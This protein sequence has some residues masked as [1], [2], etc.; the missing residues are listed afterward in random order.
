MFWD[1]PLIRQKKCD[2]LQIKRFITERSKS[3]ERNLKQQKVFG[4]IYLCSHK[5]T[6]SCK[7]QTLLTKKVK[8]IEQPQDFQHIYF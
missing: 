6:K 3:I 1:I 5:S 4:E 7:T 2:P 8:Q